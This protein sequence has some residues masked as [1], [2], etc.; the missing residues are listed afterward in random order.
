MPTKGGS[1][2]CLFE[3]HE[4]VTMSALKPKYSMEEFARRRMEIFER[5]IRPSL[6]PGDEDKYITIDIDSGQYEIDA[7]DFTATERLL[8]R[9]PE[10]QM[11]LH[12]IG[13][14]AGHGPDQGT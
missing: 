1:S 8:R 7:D 5:D 9:N 6:Q 12:R 4:G 14:K 3:N 2:F 10:A 11:W 13:H